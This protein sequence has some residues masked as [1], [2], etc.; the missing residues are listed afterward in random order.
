MYQLVLLRH[1]ESIWNKENRFTG[2]VDV[3]LTD[4][5]RDEAGEAAL[6]IKEE[7]LSF[8]LVFTSPLKRAIRTL[9]IVLD[10]LDMMWIPTVI[11]WRLN[12]RH[13]GALQG[14]NKKETAKKYGEEQVFL[15][16]RSYDMRPPHLSPDD[17]LHP[18]F[19]VKYKN[20]PPEMLPGAEALKDTYNRVL[21]FW[22]E[23]VEP[24]IKM[25]KRI[26]I[27]AHGNSLR[28]IVKYLDSVS[29]KDIVNLNIPTGVP[30]IYQLDSNL[31]A[32][33]HQY[34]GDP[35]KINEKIEGMKSQIKIFEKNPGDITAG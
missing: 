13:Y 8:D 29:N 25:G 22:Q 5:G 14:L 19:D 6:L 15:W 33:S 20:I 11:D 17:S 24:K 1:G 28:A 27:S 31:K 10:R 35:V 32:V 30:L 3:D 16:R 2:W 21:P 4:K 7:G 12:E 9:W 34:L 23:S 26:L 18:K